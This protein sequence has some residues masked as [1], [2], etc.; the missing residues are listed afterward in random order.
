[1]VNRKYLRDNGLRA[2]LGDYET[3]MGKWENRTDNSKEQNP[4]K[5][6]L[7]NESTQVYNEN[8][9]STA[10]PSLA[11]LAPKFPRFSWLATTLFR[12]VFRPP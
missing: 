2:L 8:G 6:S 7:E 4:F 5:R 10:A 12:L 9:P 3:Q 1:M 11:K